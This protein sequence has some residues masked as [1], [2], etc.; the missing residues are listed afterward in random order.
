MSIA[1][2]VKTIAKPYNKE[3]VGTFN[4]PSEARRALR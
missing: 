1:S 2:V 3:P 4:V